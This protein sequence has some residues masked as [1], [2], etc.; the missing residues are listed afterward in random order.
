MPSPYE[1]CAIVTYGRTGSTA[2][3]AAANAHNGVLIR[4]ENY[5]AFR[6]IRGYVQSVAETADRHHSGKSDHPWFGSARLDP[7]LIRSQI[8]ADVISHHLRPRKNTRWLGF[9]E[10][11]YTSAHW[12][13]Y[14][15]LLEYLLFLNTLLPGL[16]YLINIRSTADAM[17]SAWWRNEPNAQ[18]ILETTEM[19][20]RDAD[21]DLQEILG[22]Q[23]ATLIDYGHWG[24]DDQIVTQALRD[25]GLP[26]ESHIVRA[27]LAHKLSHGPST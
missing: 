22:H 4:G 25:L 12:P 24:T 8:G 1:Y 11:R 2:L 10:I 23:R 13:D 18:R 6:G 20:L 27:T 3:Q 7:R 21:R 16:R 15:T 14:D 9:K 26:A 17:R 5:S 19:W